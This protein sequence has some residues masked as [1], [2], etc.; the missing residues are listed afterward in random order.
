[1]DGFALL[2]DVLELLESDDDDDVV[3][4]AEAPFEP[5]AAGVEL[6]E[7]PFDFDEELSVPAL[8]LRA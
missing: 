8:P 5:D 2:E 6:D 1:V 7:L 3:A 4:A